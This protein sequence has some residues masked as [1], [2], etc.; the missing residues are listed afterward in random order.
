MGVALDG[1]PV[2]AIACQ[3]H[4]SEYAVRLEE[5]DTRAERKGFVL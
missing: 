2:P 5:E 3:R 4:C 1:G